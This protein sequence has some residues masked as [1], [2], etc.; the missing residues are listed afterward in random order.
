[1]GPWV[2]WAPWVP[3]GPI[4]PMGQMASHSGRRGPKNPCCQGPREPKKSK[5]IK[6]SRDPGLNHEPRVVFYAEFESGIEN[7][8]NLIKNTKYKQFLK[9]WKIQIFQKNEIFKCDF[10]SIP[11]VPGGIWG[12]PGAN[13]SAPP[14]V[15]FLFSYKAREGFHWMGPKA[16]SNTLL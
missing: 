16:F 13:F 8:Q 15:N 7:S 14:G 12:T 6:K 10:I 9:L 1:M 3:M 2:P 11:G 5:I 4:G